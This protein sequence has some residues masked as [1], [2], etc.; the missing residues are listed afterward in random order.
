M[1]ILKPD[2]SKR[3]VVL[4]IPDDDQAMDPELIELLRTSDQYML[5]AE[6]A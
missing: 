5:A 4:D 6:S 2:G 1:G 3:V